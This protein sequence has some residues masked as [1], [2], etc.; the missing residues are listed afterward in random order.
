MSHLYKYLSC[1]LTLEGNGS[2]PMIF[3]PM[4]FSFTP[5]VAP[6]WWCTLWR[7]PATLGVPVSQCCSESLLS[8]VR[9]YTQEYPKLLHGSEELMLHGEWIPVIHPNV[10]VHDYTNFEGLVLEKLVEQ[11]SWIS[12]IQSQHLI[13]PT[14]W[15]A[16]FRVT[17]QTLTCYYPFILSFNGNIL[18]D[19]L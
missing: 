18:Q 2:I 16:D 5:G 17:T 6:R 11:L 14:L 10:I 3:R 13:Y 7:V 19:L 12:R 8:S 15:I 1:K 9:R 4:S